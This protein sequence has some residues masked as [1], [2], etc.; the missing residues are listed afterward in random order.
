MPL[1]HGFS[2]SSATKAHALRNSKGHRRISALTAYDYPTARLLDEADIDVLLVGDSLGM[3]VLGFPDTTHVTLAHMLHHTAAVARAKPQALVLGDLPI[4]SYDTDDQALQSARLL[5]EAGADAVKLEGGCAKA[6][7]IVALR[8]A[9]IEVVGHIGMLPQQVLV[10]GGYRKKG[11]NPA[12]AEQLLRDAE[13]LEKA[14]VCGIVLESIVPAVASRITR[15][16]GVPTIGIGCGETTCDGEVAVI[17]DLLGSYPWFVPPFAKPEA[18]LA[19]AI[20][21][22]ARAYCQRVSGVE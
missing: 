10:E 21:A 3:V 19:T 6:D 9:G 16:V 8:R 13:A 18:D 1:A 22:A 2:M 17:T 12:A 11:N 4:H 5:L 14:G 7:T 15:S 20:S